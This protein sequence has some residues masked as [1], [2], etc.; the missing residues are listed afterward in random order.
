M[1]T[2]RAPSLMT[3]TEFAATYFTT[4]P[5][6]NTTSRW[7]AL[8]QLPVKTIGGKHYIDRF[9]YEQQTDNP[10]VNRVLTGNKGA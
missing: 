2:T 4:P 5:H 3:R 1:T 9:A 8:G 10:L 7:I 6:R